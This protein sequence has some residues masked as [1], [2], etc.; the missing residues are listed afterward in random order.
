MKKK[1]K[2]SILYCVLVALILAMLGGIINVFMMSW[3]LKYTTDHKNIS[4]LPQDFNPDYIIVLGAR[5]IDDYTVSAILADR[6]NAGLEIYNYYHS[7]V[8]IIMS[9][10]SGQGPDE[11]N[12]M[13]V[14][15]FSKGLD[16]TAVLKDGQGVDTFTSLS[17]AKEIFGAK[18]VIIVTQSF[19]LPRCLFISRSLG[20]EAY[21]VS[22]D[23]RQYYASNYIREYFARIKDFFKTFAV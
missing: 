20:I 5:A 8:P 1:I 13:S 12:A 22:S 14:Y 10:G 18:K 11:P 17:R 3:S 9:G 15:A 6:I 4:K 21:G 2:I 23:Y 7:Q 16:N 19:H